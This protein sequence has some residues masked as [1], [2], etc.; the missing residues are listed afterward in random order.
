MKTTLTAWLKL[1]TMPDQFRALRAT[2]ARL[3]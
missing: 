2:R 3:A 1:L